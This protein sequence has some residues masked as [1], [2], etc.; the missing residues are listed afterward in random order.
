M[1]WQRIITLQHN[2][3][4]HNLTL[5]K[6]VAHSRILQMCSLWNLLSLRM[7]LSL[8][9]SV[10]KTRKLPQLWKCSELP[11]KKSHFGCSVPAQIT[12]QNWIPPD[13]STRLAPLLPIHG[14]LWNNTSGDKD[15]EDLQL[16]GPQSQSSSFASWSHVA[17]EQ[18]CVLPTEVSFE[19]VSG[20]YRGK[21]FSVPS[22][23]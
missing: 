16:Q 7:E 15:S 6:C 5:I 8:S 19:M 1:F 10:G 4:L 18:K 14:L 20:M 23:I 3:E 11:L 21:D 22:E 2:P 13:K 9:P 12:C 17:K